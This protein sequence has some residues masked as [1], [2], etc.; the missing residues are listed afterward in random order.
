MAKFGKN[1]LLHYLQVPEN[2]KYPRILERI[3]RPVGFSRISMFR[4]YTILTQD[5][6]K[7]A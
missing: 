4:K 3:P 7:I 2:K 6:L 5:C 1:Q